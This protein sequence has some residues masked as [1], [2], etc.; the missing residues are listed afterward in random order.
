MFILP[1]LSATMESAVPATVATL[2]NHGAVD[3]DALLRQAEGLLVQSRTVVLWTYYLA[4][5]SLS[6][7]GLHRL[8]LLV[9][10]H[11]SQ[12]ATA[13]EAPV[14]VA[15]EAEPPTV[16]VQLPLFNERSVAARLIDACAQFDYPK[17][18]FQIQ[19][20]DDSTDNTSQVVAERVA[21]WQRLGIEIE[22]L[23][24]RERAGYKAGALQAGLRETTSDL[25]AVFDA[26]FDPDP[27]F[28]R[29]LVPRFGDSE[30]GMVQAR[31]DYANRS[32]TLLNEVQA[33]LLDGH[34]LI[35]HQARAA[36][37]AFFNFNGTAGIWRRTAI[38]D[39]GG[40]QHDTVTE[41]LDLSYRAQLAGWRFEYAGAVGVRSDLP[42]TLAA[43][44]GQQRRWTKG[45]AQ[46]LR[47]LSRPILRSPIGWRR[48]VEAFAHLGAN[49]GYPL[50][51]LVAL[52]L[53]LVITIR[54]LGFEP[55]ML[56]YDLTMLL[57]GTASVCAFYL[58]AARQRGLS[59]LR[60]IFLLP[61]LLALCMGLAWHNAKACLDGLRAQGGVFERT[62][63]G[64]YRPRRPFPWGESLLTL[65]LGCA[66]LALASAGAWVGLPFLALFVV[67]F[68]ST[69]SVLWR[70]QKPV[71]SR[72]ETVAPVEG[73]VD[74]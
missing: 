61:A 48:K 5:G 14:G 58:G 34:F 66:L 19:V 56:R 43:Y 23:R 47:K 38:D 4:L 36:K 67:G 70:R 18:R 57:F 63:K 68:A 62:P 33:L 6:L 60:G 2:A 44:R 13:R 21:H 37:G 22:H 28:L 32:D 29:R 24:R 74:R 65:Y 15:L 16:L 69:A 35:E 10:A 50:T 49:L 11:R 9:I 1:D 55:E 46:T 31:W 54:H 25:V 59:L 27:D 45:S 17:D 41:D 64:D 12:R 42:E 53:P 20:L 39:G 71:P 73:L 30:V 3:L 40:W 7:L 51:V 52:L 8:H 26:D 72:S